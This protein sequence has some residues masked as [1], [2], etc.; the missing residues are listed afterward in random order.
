MWILLETESIRVFLIG[1]LPALGINHVID[2]QNNGGVYLPIKS[3][4]NPDTEM[5]DMVL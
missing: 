4:L 2:K 5:G 1:I 3:Q